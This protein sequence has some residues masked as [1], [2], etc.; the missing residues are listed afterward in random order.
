[1]SFTEQLSQEALEYFNRVCDTPFSQQAVSFLNA[2]WPE[3]H[4]QVEFIF[5]VSWEMIKYADMNSKGIQYLHQYEEGQ[6]LD[7]DIGLY[8]YEQLCKRLDEEWRDPWALTPFEPSQ[9]EMMTAI[10]RKKELRDKVDV[11]F[12]GRVSFL[13][14]LLYQYK[15]YANPADFCQRSMTQGDEHP[16]IRK[17]RL[18]LEEVNLRIREYEAEKFRLEME[19]QKPG[20]AGLRAKNELAQINSSPLWENLNTALIKAEAAV[21]I[22]TRKFGGGGGGGGGGGEGVGNSDG[23]IWWMNKDLEE[24][25]KRYGGRK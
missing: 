12:D 11:N 10:V 24:K 7:F 5:N 8:F 20:V 13:E 19:A 21:R 3:V 14:Y 2:Y 18:A 25:Q 1:M 6:T 16:E 4:T 9:P 22:A 23:A 17:A 15:E